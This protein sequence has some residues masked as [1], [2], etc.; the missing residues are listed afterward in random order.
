MAVR[1]TVTTTATC[2]LCSVTA[3]VPEMARLPRGWKR[4]YAVRAS[5]SSYTGSSCDSSCDISRDVCP[6]CQE[7]CSLAD[8]IASFG[9]HFPWVA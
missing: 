7:S 9:T 8:L 3:P 2:D 4:L 1:T 6:A 5:Q